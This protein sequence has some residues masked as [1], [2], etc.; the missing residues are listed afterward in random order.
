MIFRHRVVRIRKSLGASAVLLLIPIFG[1]LRR[2]PSSLKPPGPWNSKAIEGIFD[3]A[4]L[5]GHK[6]VLFYYILKNMTDVDYRL[7]DGSGVTIMMKLRGPKEA[8]LDLSPQK[9]RIPYPI[10]IPAKQRQIL[11]IVDLSRTYG[12]KLEL[13]LHYSLQEYQEYEKKLEGLIQRQTPDF[14]GFVLFDKTHDYRIDLP[15][16]W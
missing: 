8:F 16:G 12:S 2:Q 13:S 9:L 7:A 15:R 6:N 4:M 11:V 14:D 3:G 10:F 1:G 5:D